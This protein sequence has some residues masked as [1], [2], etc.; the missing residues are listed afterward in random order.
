MALILPCASKRLDGIYSSYLMAYAK[1]LRAHPLYK[2]I[3]YSL[4][5]CYT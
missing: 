2:T 5:D 3:L 4:V 1:R